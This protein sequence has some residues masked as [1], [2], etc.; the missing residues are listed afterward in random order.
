GVKSANDNNPEKAIKYFEQAVELYPTFSL[1]ELALADQYSKVGRL[2][3]AAVAYKKVLEAKPDAAAAYRGLGIVL[4]KQ[5]NFKDALPSLQHSVALDR[6]SADGFLFLGFTEMQTGDYEK[7]E[8]DLLEAFKMSKSPAAHL[9]LA[10]LYTR[11]KAL[12]KA[13]GQ[14]QAFVDERPDDPR[15]PKVREAIAKLHKQMAPQK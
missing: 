13:I 6:T 8:N 9:Y 1:A 11:E 2:A 7:A 3:D 4:V 12:Q 14:L 15:V 5:K 10:D